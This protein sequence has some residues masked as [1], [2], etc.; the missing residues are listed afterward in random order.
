M[1][2]PVIISVIIYLIFAVSYS[3]Y[4]AKPKNKSRKKKWGVRQSLI[5]LDKLQ[6]I[7]KLPPAPGIKPTPTSTRPI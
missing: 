6:S 3:I 7:L 2:I 4:F 5:F 1:P